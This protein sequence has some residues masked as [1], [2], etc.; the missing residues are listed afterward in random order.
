M[1]R[2]LGWEVQFRWIPAHAGVP[3]N[4]AADQA[5]KEATGYNLDT[6]THAEPLPEPDS[7]WILM[8]TTKSTI[9]QM[10]RGEWEQSWE[11][12]KHGRELYRLGAWPGKATLNTHIGTHR[13]ISSAITQMHTGKI[14][15]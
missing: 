2:N 1:L 7:L 9:C 4:E 11:T 13:A 12:A 10:M 6:Q 15:L 5:A 8:A 3:G 14:S